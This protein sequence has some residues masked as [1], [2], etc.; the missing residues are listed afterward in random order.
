MG[1]ESEAIAYDLCVCH[2][3]PKDSNLPMAFLLK[4]EL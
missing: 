4:T 3:R 2:S 1:A